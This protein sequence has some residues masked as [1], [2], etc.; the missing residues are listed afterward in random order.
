MSSQPNSRLCVVHH[1]VVDARL[2]DGRHWPLCDSFDLDPF[3]YTSSR[4]GNGTMGTC[5]CMQRHNGL[6]LDVFYACGAVHTAGWDAEE[7]ALEQ[8]D[9]SLEVLDPSLEILDS[10]S[11]LPGPSLEVPGS[12][13]EAP[14]PS[15]KVHDPSL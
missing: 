9:P 11:Q 1:P 4:N 3:D 5:V 7:R 12:S 2:F 13:L 6:L 8:P 10:Q 15:L 14:D